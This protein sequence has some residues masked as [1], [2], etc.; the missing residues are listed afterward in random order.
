MKAT[1]ALAHPKEAHSHK[2]RPSQ[3]LIR[4]VLVQEKNGVFVII[5][6]TR[7]VLS[8][9]EHF[10]IDEMAT[11]AMGNKK[12]TEAA[13]SEWH[14]HGRLHRAA[15][16]HSA[17]NR[18]SDF[19]TPWHSPQTQT[20]PQTQTTPSL[21][22]WASSRRQMGPGSILA[23]PTHLKMGLLAHIF[24]ERP[25]NGRNHSLKMR[26]AHFGDSVLFLTSFSATC[27]QPCGTFFVVQKSMFGTA[28]VILLI[29]LP[30]IRPWRLLRIPIPRLPIGLVPLWRKW[31]SCLQ[32]GPRPWRSC[33]QV[34]PR[35][36]AE[37][38]TCSRVN[39]VVIFFVALE[40]LSF[41]LS[42]MLTARDGL[43]FFL[44]P[45][46]V[47]VVQ[48]FAFSFRLSKVRSLTEWLLRSFCIQRENPILW[49]LN[50]FSF[51]GDIGVLL[52]SDSVV[53]QNVVFFPPYGW[54]WLSVIC[55]AVPS[56]MCR[57]M[58]SV[59]SLSGLFQHLFHLVVHSLSFRRS[60]L[61]STTAVL[62]NHISRNWGD[63]TVVWFSINLLTLFSRVV[64]CCST[65][66]RGTPDILWSTM[67]L[68]ISL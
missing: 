31:R 15:Q 23:S 8:A 37:P 64:S 57:W 45:C 41:S 65:A 60:V 40:L 63:V 10:A 62:L 29:T 48:S 27:L 1:L 25:A 33:L 36:F 22:N 46:Q 14:R 19:D 49:I 35:S 54:Q 59:L 26:E 7:M 9:Q 47:L 55:V 66:E 24:F 5:F 53:Q 39:R 17:K 42:Y 43:V 2:T 44:G 38:P 58:A 13:F 67:L 12:I 3:V 68:Q 6:T 20:R 52:R 28:T 51:C 34:S 30:G 18:S 56:W 61:G 11:A 16:R 4:E 50:Y 21:P 32:V